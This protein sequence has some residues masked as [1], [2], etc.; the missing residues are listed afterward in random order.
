MVVPALSHA[1]PGPS[2]VRGGALHGP[3]AEDVTRRS[4]SGGVGEPPSP[5]AALHPAT[6]DAT[7]TRTVRRAKVWAR[8][9]SVWVRPIG[10]RT[11][12]IIGLFFL[13]VLHGGRR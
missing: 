4:C 13:R 5:L 11:R 2:D 6:M 9:C 3:S 10:F 1:L 7:E 8:M 12:I